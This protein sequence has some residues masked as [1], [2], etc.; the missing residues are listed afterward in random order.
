[1]G[2]RNRE[3]PTVDEIAAF[4]EFVSRLTLS[5]RVQQRFAGGT[6][7]VGRS[8]LFALRAL[9][10][11]GALTYRGL[12]EQMGLDP[13]TVSRLAGR[14]LDLELV[15]REVDEADKRRAWLTLSASGRKVLKGVEDVYLGYYETAI[16]DWS[17]D[18]RA[19]ARAVLAR[20]R[21]S[22]SRL[23]FDEQGRATGVARSEQSKSA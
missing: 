15:E 2:K 7:L 8:E 1:M 23:E 4:I 13:T 16:A 21:E 12:A 19:V 14:L 5:E 9:K 22:L 10:R 17:A 20:L 6:R 18:D 11:H 3:E